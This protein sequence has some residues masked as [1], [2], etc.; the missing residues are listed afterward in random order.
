[1]Q[2]H[3]AGPK[4]RTRRLVGPEIDNSII[5]LMHDAVKH[6]NKTNCWMCM[7]IPSSA[8]GP[9]VAAVPLSHL[10]F[11]TSN[12]QNLTSTNLNNVCDDPRDAALLHEYYLTTPD[13][14]N[15]IEKMAKDHIP[16][17]FNETRIIGMAIIS[18]IKG[19]F[20][21]LLTM[22]SYHAQTDCATG[23][24]KIHCNC[25]P[26]GAVCN[27]SHSIP[28]VECSTVL[29]SSRLT[30]PTLCTIR[31][32][33]TRCELPHSTDPT[34]QGPKTSRHQFTITELYNVT[35]CINITQL[36]PK[37]KDRVHLGNS[38]CIGPMHKL[39]LNASK[40][41]QSRTLPTGVF[42]AC[43]M[44]MYSYIPNGMEGTCY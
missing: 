29:T 8:E 18:K 10:Q 36:N 33:E 32:A 4:P 39:S 31:C 3:S 24:S 41:P 23:K 28:R 22:K 34:L 35:D 6:L 17:G 9:V 43:G 20:G 11:R 16:Q 30:P 15:Q 42:L 38:N 40:E 37:P 25:P 13:I 5:W 26:V 14:P 1:M 27:R 12:W 19:N 2:D 44:K 21:D 7:H